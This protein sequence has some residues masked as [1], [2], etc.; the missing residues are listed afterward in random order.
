MLLSTCVMAPHLYCVEPFSSPLYIL[1]T[2]NEFTE[3]VNEEADSL[4]ASDQ[5]PTVTVA[6]TASAALDHPI[7]TR[8]STLRQI[9]LAF[10]FLNLTE[11]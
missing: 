5:V 7:T 1:A 10:F 3:H 9:N 8:A 4:I 6:G 2:M 11:K